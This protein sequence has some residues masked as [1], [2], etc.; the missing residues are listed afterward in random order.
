MTQ[1][2]P[3]KA[4]LR[5]SMDGMLDRF[6]YRI[7]RREQAGARHDDLSFDSTHA[8]PAGAADALRSD[9]PRLVEL[10]AAYAALDCP[11]AGPTYFWN[12]DRVAKQVNLQWFRGDNAYVWQNRQLGTEVRLKRYLALQDMRAQDHLGLLNVLEEDGLFGCWTEQYGDQSPVS[13]DL[14]DSI[15]EINF[16]DTQMG[17]ARIRDLRVLDIGAGYGRLAYRMSKALKNLRRYDCID[18]VPESTYLSDYYLK[19]RQVSPPAS[20]IPLHQWQT[21]F[22]PNGY[23]IA[24]N[25]HSFSE[26]TYAAISWWLERVR[27][28][29]IPWL[30]IVPNH[31]EDLLSTEPDFSFRDFMPLVQGAGY[32]LLHKAPVYRNDEIRDLV[33]VRDHYFLFRRPDLPAPS[34]A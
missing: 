17:L 22:S 25:I 2:S 32:E 11:A 10:R 21:G 13:R 5:R 34:L 16:L 30:L 27:A 20:V 3:I 15:S 8:L 31:P 28:L 33:G 12:Q 4:A 29:N 26:C 14:L 6:G 7:V 19:F 24:L 9:H 23:D 18:A 1:G